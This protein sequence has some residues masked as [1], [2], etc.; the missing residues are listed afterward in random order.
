MFS[1][2]T[3]IYT[4]R[5]WTHSDDGLHQ[6]TTITEVLSNDSIKY[7]LTKNSFEFN[8]L[9]TCFWRIINTN[10]HKKHSKRRDGIFAY[11]NKINEKKLVERM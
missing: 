2:T 7:I 6:I 3:R 10:K 9:R 4:V 1:D 11:V 8:V 5:R